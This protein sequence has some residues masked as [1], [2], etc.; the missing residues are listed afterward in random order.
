[1]LRN[2]NN[3]PIRG[4]YKL[5]IYHN[6]LLP[7]LQFYLAVNQIPK[8]SLQAQANKYLKRLLSLSNSTTLA[9]LFH[10]K[11][12]DVTPLTEV[13]QKSK[14]SFLTS[15][16]SSPDPL[17]QELV[18]KNEDSVFPA[19][20]LA[21]SSLWWQELNLLWKLH[22]RFQPSPWKKQLFSSLKGSREIESTSHLE[23]L[24]VQSKLLD[25][26]YRPRILL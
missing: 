15:F 6:Y 16:M 20:C 7:S 1:M 3:R 18:V 5:W 12:L 23:G 24:E 10:P 2:I 11:L 21:F 8:S 14:I 19:Q 9:V 26:I 22:N 25:S 4:E 13:E 17:I